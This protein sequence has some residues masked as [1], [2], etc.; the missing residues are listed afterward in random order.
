MKKWMLLAALGCAAPYA[1]ADAA[2]FSEADTNEDGVLSTQEAKVALPDVLIVD[3]NN[4]GIIDQITTTEFDQFGNLTLRQFDANGDG[5]ADITETY[6]YNTNNRLTNYSRDDDGD[7]L[8]D[9]GSTYIYDN[10]GH[11]TRQEDDDNGDGNIDRVIVMRYNADG[12]LVR[13]EED[14]NADGG[15]HARDVADDRRNGDYTCQQQHRAEQLPGH[16]QQRRFVAAYQR[17]Q[18]GVHLGQRGHRLQHH[19]PF[20]EIQF[21]QRFFYR[22]G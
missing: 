2:K 22:Y 15:R 12:L 9:R 17:H 1:L 18:P 21:S 7:G 13:H 3:N 20:R 6:T 11:V 10:D 19:K 14:E 8:A 4:D 16:Y 5:A